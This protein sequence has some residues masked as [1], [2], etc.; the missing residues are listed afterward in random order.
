MDEDSYSYN[1]QQTEAKQIVLLLNKL[2]IPLK[3]EFFKTFLRQTTLTY[4]QQYS[5]S[6]EK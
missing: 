6:N 3:F 4:L 5:A 1:C 2:F